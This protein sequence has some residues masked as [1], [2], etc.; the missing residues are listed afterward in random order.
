MNQVPENYILVN[1]QIPGYNKK[2]LVN[3]TAQLEQVQDEKNQ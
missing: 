3:A 1:N 2:Y